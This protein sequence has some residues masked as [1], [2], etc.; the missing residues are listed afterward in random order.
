MG[1][2]CS[3]VYDFCELIELMFGSRK[4]EVEKCVVFTNW[5]FVNSDVMS[6]KM[7]PKIF[8]KAIQYQKWHVYK[9]CVW[10]GVASDHIKE[11]NSC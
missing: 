10:M 9:P 2:I 5:R 1:P 8:I 11:E 4:V 3:N 6:V 7:C